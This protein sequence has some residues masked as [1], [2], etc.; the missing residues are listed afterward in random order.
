MNNKRNIY[1]NLLNDVIT[2]NNKEYYN[3]NE[4]EYFYKPILDH[5]PYKNYKLKNLF[6][7]H[8][9]QKIKIVLQKRQ[10]EVLNLKDSIIFIKE[11]YESKYLKD[12]PF[13]DPDSLKVKNTNIKIKLWI[14]DN[15]KHKYFTKIFFD[16]E[17]YEKYINL[18]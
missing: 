13:Y 7:N 15:N 10:Y 4:F 16:K 17:D 12:K 8:E 14:F 2:V 1:S 6:Y 11:I 5:G 9:T 18:I 3:D